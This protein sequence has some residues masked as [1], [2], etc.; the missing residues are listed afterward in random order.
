MFSEMMKTRS[1]RKTRHGW[2]AGFTLIELMLVMTII[3]ILATMAVVRYDR[4]VSRAKE[5]A[6]HHDL[7]VMREAIEQYTL[8][9]EQAPQSLDD[10]VSAGY[11]GAIPTDPVTGAKDWVTDTSDAVLDPDQSSGGISDVHSGSSAVSP[12]ENTPY[13]TW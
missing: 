2:A 7:S 4:S 11:L 9:K 6:L 10:L 8:D 12:F 3:M 13:N 5:A 1:A